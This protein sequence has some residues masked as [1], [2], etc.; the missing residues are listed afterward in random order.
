MRPSLLFDLPTVAGVTDL[1]DQIRLSPSL[2]YAC[3]FMPKYRKVQI[4][5]RSGGT[6]EILCPSHELKII[7]RWILRRI[8]QN[9]P[10]DEHATAY[11]P[12]RKLR[13]HVMP[14]QHNAYFMCVDLSEFF[15]SV[16]EAK[17]AELFASLGYRGRGLGLLTALC[18]H[19][20]CLPQGAPTSPTIA[21]I[22]CK[23]MDRRIVGY[24]E[25]RGI[26][27]TRYADDMLF[28]A[29]DPELLSAALPMIRKIIADEG[30][31]E[32]RKKFR[33]F[34]PK[35]R[36][37]VT[38]LVQGSKGFGIGRKREHRLRAL[39]FSARRG[40]SPGLAPKVSGWLA[41]V[42]AVDEE[43]HTRLARY[44]QIVTLR[45]T[46]IRRQTP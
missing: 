32:N 13:E 35:K 9:I 30:F 29:R 41:Y 1:A 6:R 8:L 7:Q 17:V 18:T 12:G 43:R 20:A 25:R 37:P 24:V 2:V 26:R 22:V 39:L 38:G 28:S 21:N 31:R 5:K 11:A 27:Y 16:P 4:P 46:S 34:G 33:R 45:Q 10:I 15:P 3:A 19:D 44:N 42:K 14:H 23:R 40:S 36:Q